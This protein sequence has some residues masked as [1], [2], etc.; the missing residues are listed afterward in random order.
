MEHKGESHISYRGR[1]RLRYVMYEAVVSVVSHSPEFWSIH[2][3]C[4]TREKNPLK[5]MQ[6]LI[7]VACKLI[8]VFYLILQTGAT[9]D[10]AKLM[11]NIQR[12]LAA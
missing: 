3:Y 7:A 9:Y 5:K 10:A 6:S 2:Q 1:K 8:R 11:G 4:T 12:S